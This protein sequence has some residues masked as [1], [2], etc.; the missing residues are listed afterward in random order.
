MNENISQSK[1]TNILNLS[2]KKKTCYCYTI[3]LISLQTPLFVQL[4]S[5]LK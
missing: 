3:A 1:K 2:K 5:Y 4:P